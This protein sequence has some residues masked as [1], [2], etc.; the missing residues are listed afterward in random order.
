MAELISMYWLMAAFTGGMI[1]GGS[2]VGFIKWINMWR[3]IEG[4]K[5]LWENE[6]MGRVAMIREYAKQDAERY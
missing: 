5:L 1:A 2:L 3:D 4:Y 6:K